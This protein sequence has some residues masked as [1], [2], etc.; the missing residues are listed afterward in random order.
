MEHPT[1]Y[2]CKECGAVAHVSPDGTIRREC[3]HTGTVY[4]LLDVTLTG[5]G[6]A[7]DGNPLL[8]YFRGIGRAIMR[9]AAQ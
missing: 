5:E 9:R 7:A 3:A 4:M 6:R 2:V 1:G 8:E